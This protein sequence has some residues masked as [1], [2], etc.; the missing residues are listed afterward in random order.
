MKSCSS[1]PRQLFVIVVQFFIL[2][3]Q[4]DTQSVAMCKRNISK[5]WCVFF[6]LTELLPNRFHSHSS[7]ALQKHLF[8]VKQI[9]LVI[10][11]VL[12]QMG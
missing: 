11:T 2:T 8:E 12:L 7:F 5:S 9:L 4:I 10:P 6:N 1:I 3:K